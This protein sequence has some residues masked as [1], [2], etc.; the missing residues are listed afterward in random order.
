MCQIILSLFKWDEST[1]LKEW[2]IHDV[3]AEA[4]SIGKADK[5]ASELADA[6]GRIASTFANLHGCHGFAFDVVKDEHAVA[7]YEIDMSGRIEFWCEDE[8]HE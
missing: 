7:S 2:W 8:C 6:Y 5:F 4:D 1:D 3:V